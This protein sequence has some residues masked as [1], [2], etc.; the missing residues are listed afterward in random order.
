MKWFV[1]I[2]KEISNSKKEKKV[3]VKTFINVSIPVGVSKIKEDGKEIFTL[4][5]P[6]L[7]LRAYGFSLEEAKKQFDIIASEFFDDVLKKPSIM[8]SQAKIFGWT[9]KEHNINDF[10]FN[11]NKIKNNF[12][13][14]LPYARTEYL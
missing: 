13:Q 2:N 7:P 8:N 10:S 6:V 9:K 14:I 5:S 11:E 12:D 3:L 1:K 4:N